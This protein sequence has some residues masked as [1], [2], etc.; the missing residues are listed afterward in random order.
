MEGKQINKQTNK[1]QELQF[2]EC[3]KNVSSTK[4]IFMLMFFL[5]WQSHCMAS[6]FILLKENKGIE[7]ET[8]RAAFPSHRQYWKI[9]HLF[10]SSENVKWE[11][12]SFCLV[13]YM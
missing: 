5:W 13:C 9:Q 11:L 10:V 1:E 12:F 2:W 7:A 6:D 4:P 3:K 8:E